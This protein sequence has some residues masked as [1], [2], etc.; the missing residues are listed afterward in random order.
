MTPV[1][2]KTARMALPLTEDMTIDT[3]GVVRFTIQRVIAY[4][5][6]YASIRHNTRA[7]KRDARPA[8]GMR[9]S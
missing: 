5:S 3:S 6:T 8:T 2:C 9:P 1:S 4:D 7:G